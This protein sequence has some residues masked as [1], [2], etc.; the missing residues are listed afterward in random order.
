M[1]VQTALDSVVVP[2]L[3]VAA[4][5]VLD[6]LGDV[7]A[8]VQAVALEGAQALVKVPAL[9]DVRVIVKPPVI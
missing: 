1:D 7:V 6:A 2:V 4:E 8:L 5:D 9:E 3:A